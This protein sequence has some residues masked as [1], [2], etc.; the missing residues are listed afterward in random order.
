MKSFQNALSKAAFSTHGTRNVN[1]AEFYNK[2]R[3]CGVGY[4]TGVPDSLL[5][6]FCA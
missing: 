5:K 6:D 1:V 3:A 2:A 4:F